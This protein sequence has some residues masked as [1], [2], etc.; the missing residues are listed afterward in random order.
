VTVSIS[1]D[2]IIAALKALSGVDFAGALAA[3]RSGDVMGELNSASQVI[4]V[5]ADFF[6]E[7]K[8]AADA[9][10]LFEL[11][12]K[13]REAGLWRPADPSDPAMERAAG[14]KPGGR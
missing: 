1:A 8:Y 12:I 3:V 14:D 13:A 5:V 4:N 7:A 9:I 10:I 11:I 2:E 6:P